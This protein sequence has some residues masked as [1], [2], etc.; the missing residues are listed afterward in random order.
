MTSAGAAGGT[1]FTWQH[2]D[3]SVKESSVLCQ[4]ALQEGVLF[5]NLV[6]VYA[7]CVKRAYR[8]SYIVPFIS[9]L[10]IISVLWVGME[11]INELIYKGGMVI[12]VVFAFCAAMSWHFC[13]KK[14]KMAIV[15]TL[16]LSS[17]PVFYT[18]SRTIHHYIV[19]SEEAKFGYYVKLPG[20]DLES[21]RH[22]WY[23][24]F[25]SKTNEMPFIF[26]QNSP[27][28]APFTNIRQTYV[29]G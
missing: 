25:W 29:G 7:L 14:R 15:F 22:I 23:N 26:K 18:I 20:G 10:C 11:A 17:L 5:I 1:R 13:S 8:H 19:D 21:P 16:L 3:G 24:R 9:C 27:N 6:L 2:L 4:A 12:V 28:D